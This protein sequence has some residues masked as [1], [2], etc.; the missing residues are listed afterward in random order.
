[1]LFVNDS[2][3]LTHKT[4]PFFGSDSKPDYGPQIKHTLGYL[5]RHMVVNTIPFLTL[6]Y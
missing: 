4:F 2:Q 1:M 3:K 5:Q 6:L